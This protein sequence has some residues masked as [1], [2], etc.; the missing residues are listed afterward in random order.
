MGRTH[1]IPAELDELPRRLPPAPHAPVARPPGPTEDALDD[2]TGQ[3]LGG[4][5]NPGGEVH[6]HGSR[7]PY[8]YGG[9]N[10]DGV[11]AGAGLAT[12][13]NDR[14]D[15]DVGGHYGG[16]EWTD[17][18]DGQV[19][20]GARTHGGIA[21]TV[22]L[23]DHVDL[24][25]GVATWNEGA[26]T[27]GHTDT[28]GAQANAVEAA[29]DV[30]TDHDPTS[31]TDSRLRLGGSLGAG[32]ELRRHWGD[33]D[34]DGIPEAGFG[35]DAGPVSFDVESEIAGGIYQQGL[36]RVFDGRTAQDLRILAAEV[37][38]WWND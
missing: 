30:H 28:L 4:G 10:E 5:N 14:V 11:A 36:G 37:Q 2:V 27:D 38:N 25:F 31:R 1:D 33:A 15:V 7:G 16:G 23:G 3:L 12:A 22:H 32:G 6:R 19:Y 24:E 21:P 8:A 34:S 26:Y 29:L 20:R 13:H 35:V 18:S 17:A 9:A